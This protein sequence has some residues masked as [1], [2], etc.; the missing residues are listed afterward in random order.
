MSEAQVLLPQF[1]F[2][3]IVRSSGMSRQAV[4][5]FAAPRRNGEED[6]LL[7]G[8]ACVR[9]EMSFRMT[10]NDIVVVPAVSR[11]SLCGVSD[12]VCTHAYF[13]SHHESFDEISL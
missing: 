1:G 7:N 9:I 10:S 13:F 12:N 4:R 5:L 3:S 8:P 6:V 2:V 11:I